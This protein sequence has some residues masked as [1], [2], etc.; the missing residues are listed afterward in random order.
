MKKTDR[1][2]A[3]S[4]Q[5]AVRFHSKEIE[6]IDTGVKKLKMKTRSEFIRHK[7]LS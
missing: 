6:K 7:T 4:K 1:R 2:F 5:I 3:P